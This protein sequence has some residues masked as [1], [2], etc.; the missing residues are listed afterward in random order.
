MAKFGVGILVSVIAMVWSGAE[1]IDVAQSIDLIY[2]AGPQIDQ[3]IQV[4]KNLLEIG[5]ALLVAF[6][7]GQSAIGAIKA[8]QPLDPTLIATVKGK[9]IRLPKFSKNKEKS[10]NIWLDSD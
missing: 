7:F 10:N 5:G 1:N 3:A 9:E 4:G 6:G 2:E 8:K